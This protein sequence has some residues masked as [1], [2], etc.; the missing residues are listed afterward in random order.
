MKGALPPMKVSSISI[1]EPG[2]AHPDE[3]LFLQ[4]V[5]DSLKHEPC[6]FLSDAEITGQFI[7]TKPVLAVRQHPESSHPLVES[8]SGILK[9]GSNLESELFVASVAEPQTASLNKRILG[10]FATWA[11]YLAI[12]PAQLLRVLECPFRIA[13][14]HNRLGQSLRFFHASN[15]RR[16]FVCVKY[17]ITFFSASVC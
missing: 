5:T 13:K 2:A 16:L 15:V 12:A 1:S 6:R 10:R 17:I 3:G 9:D 8:E 4:D 7:R 11:N 14:V